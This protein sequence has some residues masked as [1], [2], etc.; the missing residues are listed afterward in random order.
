MSWKY[1]DMEDARGSLTRRRP[2]PLTEAEEAAVRGRAIVGTPE[3]VA[4]RIAA[5]RDVLGPN[6][7]FVARAYFPGL[8]PSIQRESLRI[9]GE[10]VRPLLG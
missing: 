6:G 5:Y 7:H 1:E 9:L 2:P 8:D 4:E 10:E 3:E